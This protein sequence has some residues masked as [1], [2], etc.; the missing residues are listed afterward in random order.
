MH[1][2]YEKYKQIPIQVKASL[3]FL[4]CSFLQRGISVIT[5][6]IF[7]RLMNSSE[8][9]EFGTFNSWMGIITIFITL[10]LYSG[11]YTQGLI[12]F[13]DERKIFSSSLQGLNLVLCVIWAAVYFVFRT[14][15]NSLFHL[16][17]TQM[18]AMLVMIWVGAA[19]NFWLAEQRVLLNYRQLVGVT[20]IISLSK[21]LVGILFVYYSDDK[22]TARILGLCLVELIGYTFFP[23]WQML[24]GK[25]FYSS[26]FWKY[27]VS[28][29]LPLIPHYLS[30]VA[31]NSSDRIM[32]R[33]IVGTSESGI[34]N[35]AYS[36]SSI[37]TLFNTSLIHTL[38]PWMYQKIKDKDLKLI[39]RIGYMSLIIIAFV[40]L[41]LIIFAPEVV[42]IFAP[43]EYMDAIWVIPPVAMSVFF[44]FAYSLFA[45]FEFYYK[46]SNW[47]MVASVTGAVANLILNYIFIHK[48][49]YVAAGYTTLVCYIIYS[50][51]HYIF[52]DRVIKS[53][54]KEKNI[55]NFKYLL[56][57]SGTFL[58]VSFLM[59]LTYKAYIMRYFLIVIMVILTVV[60]R[61]KIIEIVKSIVQLRKKTYEN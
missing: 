47:I 6:P 19:F 48:C 4:V 43:P 33:S 50:V 2:L 21:P 59:M 3:W 55:Y 27:A 35:L 34:Y 13:S 7:T 58:T 28:F 18:V 57:I 36:I 25:V 46:K 61:N 51:M 41:V 15:W 16:S 54:L 60:Y 26:K 42:S 44:M 1:K 53:E 11:V 17:T 38:N 24:K 10:N 22:V 39:P 14:F 12:R 8:Y 5:T 32:I 31:L 30:Q 9:G 56:Y 29:N 23:I 49:G 52:M 40:N 45:C 37:M 20:L